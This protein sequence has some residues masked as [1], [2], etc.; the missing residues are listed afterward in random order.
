MKNVLLAALA[1]LATTRVESRVFDACSLAHELVD[2]YGFAQATVGEWVCLTYYES[3]WDTSKRGPE[4]SNGSF[5][6]GLFQ[7]NDGFWCYPPDTY[8]DCNVAC[9]SKSMYSYRRQTCPI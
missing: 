5:D 2:K 7:I 9:N 1:L 6:Y 3:S 8:A 4:N